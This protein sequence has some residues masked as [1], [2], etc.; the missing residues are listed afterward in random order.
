M[1]FLIMC[2]AKQY[3]IEKISSFSYAALS[4]FQQLFAKT[5]RLGRNKNSLFDVTQGT[6]QVSDHN[7]N[8]VLASSSE[9]TL[10]FSPS[11]H[12]HGVGFRGTFEPCRFS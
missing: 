12:V 11:K 6:Y 4:M 1:A 10:F 9:N 7:L 2:V 8:L 5:H 3:P